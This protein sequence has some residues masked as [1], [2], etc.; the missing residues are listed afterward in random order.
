M[1]ASVSEAAIYSLVE[2]M[3]KQQS[4]KTSRLMQQRNFCVVLGT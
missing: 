1:F 3:L 4:N 2:N